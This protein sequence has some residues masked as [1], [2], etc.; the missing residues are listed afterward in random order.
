MYKVVDHGRLNPKKPEVLEEAL[1]KLSDEGYELVN[2]FV[3]DIVMFWSIWKKKKDSCEGG[4]CGGSCG[5]KC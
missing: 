1:N 4:G 5:G 3:Q 2:V